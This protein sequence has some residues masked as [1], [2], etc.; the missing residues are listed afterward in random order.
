MRSL[1]RLL[2]AFAVLAPLSAHADKKAEAKEHFGKAEEAH[3]DGR[4][5]DA[6]TE[7]NI[8]YTLDPQPELLYAIG[9]VHVMK[10]ECVEAIPFYQRFLDSNPSDAATTKTK[11]AIET[12]KRLQPGEK[13]RT[14]KIYIQ[15]PGKTTTVTRETSPWYTDAVGDTFLILGLAAGGGAG[16]F[17][18][19]AIADRNHAD[20]ATSY[21]EYDSLLKGAQQKQMYS[22]IAA[23][24]GGA[25]VTIALIT[26]LV[27][28][29]S[30]E[31]RTIAVVPASDGAMVTWGGRF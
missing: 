23:G 3:K 25:L 12:C 17:Y 5:D 26:Y 27:R 22:I 14:E 30:H 29:R 28:D 7:L 13:V 21:T 15:V 19:Q 24:S 11:E 10:G 2:F 1:P 8:A 6:L 9:Q 16:W 4:Y 31:R 20:Q 18:S